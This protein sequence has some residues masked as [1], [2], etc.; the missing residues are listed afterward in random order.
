MTIRG[1]NG[2]RQ[3]SC[4][5]TTSVMQVR[6]DSG[7]HEGVSSCTGQSGDTQCMSGLMDRLDLGSEERGVV[8]VTPRLP[9]SATG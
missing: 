8:K 7:L 1:G 6:D 2:S 9:T 5:A 3:T 4:Q